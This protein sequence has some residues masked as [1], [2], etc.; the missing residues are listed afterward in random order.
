MIEIQIP[1]PKVSIL[2]PVYNREALIGECIQSALDQTVTNIEI[3]IVDNASTD[4]TW[5]ICQQY[6]A[7][8]KRIK[9]FRNDTNIGP[10][11]NWLRCVSEARGEFGKILFSDDLIFP[12]FLEHTLCHIENTEVAFVSTAAIIGETPNNG[13]AVYSNI[14][15]EFRVPVKSYWDLLIKVSVPYSPGA[16]IF[17]MSD[18]RKNLLCSIPTKIYKDFTVNGAGPDVLLYGL[19]SLNYKYVVMLS[20]NDVFFRIHSGSISMLNSNNDVLKG[21]RAALSWFCI[22]KLTHC[23]WATYMARSW[24]L[25]MRIEHKLLSIQKYCI[26]YEGKGSLKEVWSVSWHALSELFMFILKQL[27]RRLGKISGVKQ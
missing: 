12:Q 4:K 7:K 20:N 1:P 3:I 22:N 8:D 24:L 26:M 5:E 11:R 15:K 23:H 10:V 25:D 19:T 27:A 9:I 6:A 13:I 2:I 17:R 18:I 14:Y 16:A 21:Y